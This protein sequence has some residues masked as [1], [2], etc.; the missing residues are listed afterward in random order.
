MHFIQI[1]EGNIFGWYRECL[2][3]DL[4]YYLF[5]ILIVPNLV[6]NLLSKKCFQSVKYM[7]HKSKWCLGLSLPYFTEPSMGNPFD[8]IVYN[9]KKLF[10]LTFSILVDF[11]Q[12]PPLLNFQSQLL[13]SLIRAKLKLKDFYKC[14]I[15][16]RICFWCGNPSDLEWSTIGIIQRSRI[17][18]WNL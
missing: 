18:H 3:K 14:E 12:L 15:F 8:Y 4:A 6:F 2:F 13:A 1:C 5:I 11:F 10:V 16:R 17:Q 7:T 9:C